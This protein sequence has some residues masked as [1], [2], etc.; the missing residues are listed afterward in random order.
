MGR[1]QLLDD[2]CQVRYP[3]RMTAVRGQPYIHC[4]APNCGAMYEKGFDVAAIRANAKRDGWTFHYIGK[5]DYCPLH[6]V[7]KK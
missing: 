2:M 1:K 4:D 6:P 3:G 5:R 7:E